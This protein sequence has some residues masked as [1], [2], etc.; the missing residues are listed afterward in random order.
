MM[1]GNHLSKDFF[2]LVKAI[3]EAKSKQ[4]EDSIIVSEVA[5]LKKVMIEANVSKK[6][7]KEFLIR[8]VYVEM[9]G[10]D[11]SF[12]YIKAIELAASKNLIQKRVG[13]LCSGLCL[14]PAHE[15]RF[16]LVNQL[17][18]DMKSAN[19]LEAGAALSAIMRLATTDMIPALLDHV[20]KL[21]AHP[22]ELVRKK[23]VMVLH[24]FFQLD[25]SAVTHLGDAMRRTLCDKDPSVMGAALCLLHEMIAAAPAGF[26]ELVPSFVSILKQIVEHRL[27]RDFDYHRIPA[28]WNQLR[29]LRILALLGRAD[30]AASE[31]MY[32]VLA[33]VMRRADT[34]INIGY[35]IVY[36]CV[37][38]ITSIYPN[39]TLLDEAAKSISRF[40]A[41]DNHNLKYLGIT[42]LAQVVEGH[43]NYAAQHQLA[44][45]ECLENVDDT[46]KRKT[47][48]LLYRMINPVNVEF[49]AS[50]LL[51]SLQTSTDDFLRA[52]LVSRLCTAAERFA[53]SN[54]WYVA[55]VIAVLEVAGDLVQPAVAQNLIALI[56]EGSGEDEAAD[57]LLRAG[58]ADAFAAMLQWETVPDALLPVLAWVLGEY[59]S[60]AT[61]S[62]LEDLALD[63]GELCGDDSRLRAAGPSA[64]RRALL[65]ALLKLVARL[66]ALRGAVPLAVAE[67][68][69]QLCDRF[70]HSA[71]AELQQ[72]ALEFL[73]LV[74]LDAQAATADVLPDVLPHDASLEDPL[75]GRGPDDAL[76]FLDR[77]VA[78]ALAAGAAPYAPPDDDDDDDDAQAAEPAALKFAAYARPEAPPSAPQGGGDVFHASAHDAGAGAPAPPETRGN[79]I[80]GSRLSQGGLAAASG[81]WGRPAQPPDYP[82]Q[83][84]QLPVYASSAAP[85]AQPAPRQPEPAQNAPPQKSAEQEQKERMAAAL[86]GGVGGGAA[87]PKRAQRPTRAQPQRPQAAATPQQPAPPQAVAPPPPPAPE[88]DLLGD[89]LGDTTP[90]P[91]GRLQA[92]A[93][94]DLGGMSLLGFSVPTLAAAPA[95]AAQAVHDPFAVLA[96]P[97]LARNWAPARLSTNDFG[98]RWGASPHERRRDVAAPP[99]ASTLSQLAATLAAAGLHAVESIAATNELILAAT[100]AH[101][102]ASALWHTKLAG[103]RL[104]VTVRAPDPAVA[105]LA[106]QDTL[107]AVA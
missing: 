8:L 55:T 91:V 65:S 66:R 57:A 98:Q 18:Q 23:V 4:Q 41:S 7:M 21:L 70:A 38:T 86:F 102:G 34:G 2:D 43:P 87:P 74:E 54:E 84:R 29:L 78:S 81:P 89:L 69:S 16:M 25:A 58:A 92:Q 90:T 36:E 101:S 50:K 11:A 10:H 9:L 68:A 88:V 28:P 59:G 31:G 72:R 61:A 52:A 79:A 20:S 44:V 26:K 53:P 63:V 67:L 51:S 95:Q 1:S 103:S 27:P 104:T 3:G 42:G 6:K 14:S 96:A 30:Q 12:G 85:A 32:E 107:L 105:D 35:A 99:H 83:T 13:Y 47:L 40:V 64:P 77:F 22:K 93:S 39:S 62:S 82:S 100:H 5:T 76:G 80:G 49:I 73:G 48:D 19:Y 45:I 37:R 71:D 60:L 15:F 17:Q 33:D 75:D 97:A 106:L 24:R 94:D 56:A 46:L